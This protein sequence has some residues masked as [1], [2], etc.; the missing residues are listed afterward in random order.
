LLTG[1]ARPDRPVDARA[2]AHRQVAKGTGGLDGISQV[3][4]TDAL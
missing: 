4:I 2:E 3:R 1:C